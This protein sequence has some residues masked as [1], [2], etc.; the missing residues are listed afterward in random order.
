[1]VF[2]IKEITLS[3]WKYFDSNCSFAGMWRSNAGNAYAACAWCFDERKNRAIVN[4]C[5]KQ[6]S[7]L[8]Y[9][10]TKY[11]VGR[12][13]GRKTD[14]RA[15]SARNATIGVSGWLFF[16]FRAATGLVSEWRS[17][18]RHLLA[19]RPLLIIMIASAYTVCMA[20]KT[21]VKKI[22]GSR[23][24][25]MHSCT[26]LISILRLVSAR[27]SPFP[28]AA[29]FLGTIRTAISITNALIQSLELFH[30]NSQFSK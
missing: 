25:C 8:R 14:K 13:A 18:D 28:P 30:K 5:N 16:N 6:T 22:G 17:L 9:V 2:D 26:A 20:A 15:W 21:A 27:V 24:A 10:M 19:R 23:A 12:H 11:P 7:R 1:L 4:S 3:S 29:N